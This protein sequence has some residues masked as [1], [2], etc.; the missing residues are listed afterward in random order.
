MV[1]STKS[2]TFDFTDTNGPVDNVG[3]KVQE[4]SYKE[5]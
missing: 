1:S 4:Q 5:K 3:K 2:L